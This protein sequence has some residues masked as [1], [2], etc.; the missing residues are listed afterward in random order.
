VKG[1]K[2]ADCKESQRGGMSRVVW[3][4]IEAGGEGGVTLANGETLKENSRQGEAKEADN[5]GVSCRRGLIGCQSRSN[6]AR[7]A[8]NTDCHFAG[9]GG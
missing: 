2:K 6:K 5:A 7:T 8:V 9:W 1:G 3:G 4:H